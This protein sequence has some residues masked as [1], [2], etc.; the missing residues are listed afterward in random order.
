MS[1][2]IMSRIW[3]EGNLPS[4][5]MFVLLA[6]ADFAD[7][8]GGNIYPSID[9][10]AWKCNL[11]RRQ[12]QVIVKSLR[13]K[14]ILKVVRSATRHSPHE[15]RIICEAIPAKEP[16]KS[17]VQDS[18]PL[19][20]SGVQST[21]SRGA[22]SGSSGVQSG[23][24]NPSMNHQEPSIKEKKNDFVG[25]GLSEDEIQALIAADPECGLF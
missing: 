24:P 12:T 14:G 17:G 8:A 18:T 15:Y 20:T 13:D 2:R 3:D 5:E 21:T 10:L 9:R 23:A 19:G 6:L 25:E 11:K 16:W 7:D 4:N 1:I 22:V